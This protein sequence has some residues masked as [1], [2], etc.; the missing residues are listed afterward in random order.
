MYRH[1]HIP[2]E[3]RP[4]VAATRRRWPRRMLVAV[5]ASVLGLLPG[6]PSL[7][8]AG[9]AV[10]QAAQPDQ[11]HVAAPAGG[12][13]GAVPP[14]SSGPT[15]YPPNFIVQ[16]T[17]A[18]DEQL[19]VAATLEPGHAPV[20]APGA[21]PGRR[22]RPARLQPRRRARRLSPAAA[23]AVPAAGRLA[24][25]ARARARARLARDPGRPALGQPGPL[26]RR[27]PGLHH[28]PRPVPAQGERPARRQGAGRADAGRAGRRLE[29]PAA[30][31]D[32]L[33]RVHRRG[34]AANPVPPAAGR[35]GPPRGP[36]DGRSEGHHRPAPAAAGGHPRLAR[37]RHLRRLQLS[38]WYWLRGA[39]M[40]AGGSNRGGLRPGPKPGHHRPA[41][42]R[43]PLPRPAV[44]LR[45]PGRVWR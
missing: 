2:A 15:D 21:L 17:G 24:G 37:R 34:A 16:S 36:L 43:Q 3:G 14:T 18:P 1:D 8:P 39:P 31:G 45:R 32:R 23:R 5:A 29:S 6:I 26:R 41:Q 4:A 7:A 33:V 42:R 10:V 25:R 11:P 9:P 28:G 20:P 30:D 22:Q 38:V 19:D 27:L 13:A 12:L 40:L 44:Q 35:G